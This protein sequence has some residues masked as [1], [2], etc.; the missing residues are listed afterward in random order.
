M[1]ACPAW[2][3][4]ALCPTATRTSGYD[5]RVRCLGAVVL[6]ACA[7]CYSPSAPSGAPCD[8]AVGNCPSGQACVDQSGAFVCL[9]PDEARDGALDDA[10][11][12]DGPDAFEPPLDAP[13]DPNDVDGD[14]KSVV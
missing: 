4:A 10:T 14:R 11:R 8:P 3:K 9:R 6:V 5:V 13:V 12:A 1:T 7:A 2:P